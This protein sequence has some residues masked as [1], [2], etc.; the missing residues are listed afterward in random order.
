[1][2]LEQLAQADQN[3]VVK[4]IQEFYGDFLAVHHDLFSFD[5]PSCFGDSV[6]SWD[7]SRL[8]RTVEG[9]LSVC[10]AL[11]KRPAIRYDRA[12]PMAQ[13]LAK[14][15]EYTI[16]QESTLFVN[17]MVDTSPQLIILDRRCDP[18]TPLLSQWTYE[19]MIHELFTISH[20]I[21]D[22]TKYVEKGQRSD[23]EQAAA[24]QLMISADTDAFFQRNMYLNIGDLG[25]N[26]KRTRERRQRIKHID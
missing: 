20:N 11:K 7:P 3:S 8:E 23:R 1:M 4:D 12:S 18:V 6:Q 16:S 13:R 10:L 9:L 5:I 24:S 25:V 15:L 26:L 22:L 19:A 2:Y 17:R 21:V 14:E